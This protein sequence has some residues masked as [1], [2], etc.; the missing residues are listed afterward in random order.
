[1]MAALFRLVPLA[2]GI[3]FCIIWVYALVTYDPKERPCDKDCESCPFPPEGCEWKNH[4]EDK[5]P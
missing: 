5:N 3:V 4:K 1:M 2:V